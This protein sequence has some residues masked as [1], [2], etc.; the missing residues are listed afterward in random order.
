MA[1]W[2]DMHLPFVLLVHFGRRCI[3]FY[4]ISKLVLENS[5]YSLPCQ[6]SNSKKGLHRIDLCLLMQQYC[7]C[8]YHTFVQPQMVHRID[9]TGK[10][11]I[12]LKTR[13]V[14]WDSST[15]LS[16]WKCRYV[17]SE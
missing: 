6:E 10:D 8:Q 3:K 2:K 11:Q 14:N 12:V 7:Y 1:R 4:N 17:Q 13:P 15:W 9:G 5:Q 16:T